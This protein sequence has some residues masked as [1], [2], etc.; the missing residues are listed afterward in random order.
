MRYLRCAR[1]AAGVEGIVRRVA[2]DRAVRH[3]LR[4]Q[5]AALVQKIHARVVCNLLHVRKRVRLNAVG[6][7]RVPALMRLRRHHT[8]KCDETRLRLTQRPRAAVVEAVKI[9]VDLC[10]ADRVLRQ[11]RAKAELL[12]SGH[13]KSSCK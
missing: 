5:L 12:C 3:T 11:P 2:E 4:Q 6:I 7:G 8:A 13:K 10:E 1:N 9:V